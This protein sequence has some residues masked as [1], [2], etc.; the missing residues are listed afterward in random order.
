V[1]KTWWGYDNVCISLVRCTFKSLLNAMK[2]KEYV[3][4]LWIRQG[5]LHMGNYQREKL[6]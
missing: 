4:S 5:E 6:G 3:D 2:D 1:F